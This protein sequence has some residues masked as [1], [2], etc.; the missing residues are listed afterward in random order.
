MAIVTLRRPLRDLAGGR[1]DVPVDGS[2]VGDVLRTLEH[3]HPPLRGWILDERG[4]IRRHVLVFVN[5]DQADAATSLRSEDR[6]H[7]LP[8]IS[9]G[10][11]EMAGAD[12]DGAGAEPSHTEVLV[13][14]RKGLFI[15]R[16]PRDGRLDVAVRAFEGST[17]EYAIRDPRTGRYLASV[18]HGQFG[19]RLYVTSD[20]SGEWEQADG[21]RFPEDAG[22]AIE[23]IWAIEPGEAPGQL[24]AGVA[25]AALFT[26]EDG[27]SSWR[28]VR[29]LWDQPDRASWQPGAGGLALHSICPW[30]GD[31]DR[32]AIGISAN[33]VWITEDRGETWRRSNRGLIARYVPEEARA[34]TT[35]LCVHDMQRSPVR[36]E[37]LFIQFH[38]GVYRSDDAGGTWTDIGAG[39]PS[40]FG[41]PLVVDPRDPDSAYVIPLTGAEDRVT[42]GGRVE[43]WETRDAGRTWRARGAGLPP[44]D[45][46][47][48]IL[49]QAF[50][51]DAGGG[52]WFGATSG[53]VFGSTDAGRTWFTAAERLPPV[54]S[55][56]A[57]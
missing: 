30:P 19:P 38:W 10:A 46:F 31:P 8:A 13:G 11:P 1:G 52:L 32:L 21:P 9:G 14:T 6:L 28:L 15:L 42:P 36:P 24:W 55:V 18:T 33:G 54:Y 7:V 49:R 29:G 45:A 56:R 17:V 34:T 12:S 41:F 5:A 27:G 35:A 16:G 3:E 39:L 22:E 50:D 44:R 53:D 40:D 4:E 48:T 25:P 2:T 47:L 23:R 37:R 20:P 43:V 57:A 51:A 26:S